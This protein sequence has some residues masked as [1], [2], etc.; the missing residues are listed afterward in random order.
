[1]LNIKAFNKPRNI[2]GWL[3]SIP[4]VIG[5]GVMIVYP[6]IFSFCLSFTGIRAS[7]VNVQWNSFQNYVWL[8]SSNAYDFWNGL[9][10]AFEFSIIS[11][12]L[13]T[14]LGFF[15][16]YLL[17]SMGK[18]MQSVYRVL[19]YIPCVLPSAVVAVM[20][21]FI[22][23]YDVGLLFRLWELFGWEQVLWLN[24]PNV[25]LWSII[26]ANTWR[27]VGITMVLYFVNMNAVSKDVLEG[28]TLD[29]AN[30]WMILWRFI[31]PLTISSTKMNIVLSFVGGMKSYDLFFMLEGG[32]MPQ[33]RPVGLVIYLY[34]F[35]QSRMGWAI[36]MS[37]M[38]SIILGVFTVFTNKLLAKVEKSYE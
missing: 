25:V 32:S 23:A 24:D 36:V 21:N 3:M 20:W 30:R 4:A 8:F 27:F 5:V 35:R 1:M 33:T 9:L 15:L 13:Q 2:A 29:G 18:Y 12:I 38:L 7:V 10:V 22:Y 28:A 11:T 31:F 17:Y 26:I 34:A 37:F 6:I 19:L 16:A 14:V